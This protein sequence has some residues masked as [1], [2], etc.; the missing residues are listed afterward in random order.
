MAPRETAP[1]KA[2]TK[3][4]IPI[5]RGNV[6]KQRGGAR[7]QWDVAESN[8]RDLFK[9]HW[10]VV[11]TRMT[12]HASND[13]DTSLQYFKHLS[14]QYD[15][16]KDIKLTKEFWEQKLDSQYTVFDLYSRICKLNNDAYSPLDVGNNA[17][18]VKIYLD[19]LK[20]MDSSEESETTA[21]ATTLYAKLCADTNCSSCWNHVDASW[22]SKENP[23][24]KGTFDDGRNARKERLNYVIM[25]CLMTKESDILTDELLNIGAFIAKPDMLKRLGSIAHD[26]WALS[27]L[28]DFDKTSGTLGI[29]PLDE[30]ISDNF[31]T[32]REF[33]KTPKR[34]MQLQT[35]ESLG[36]QMNNETML[37]LTLDDL[38][39]LP[40]NT[41]ILDYASAIL[42]LHTFRK[43]AF[44]FECKLTSQIHDTEEVK[45]TCKRSNRR[46]A[47]R[48]AASSMKVGATPP[49]SA[50]AANANAVEP[51]GNGTQEQFF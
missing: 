10:D 27:R 45:V 5:G 18:N 47:V 11:Q 26:S 39:P 36:K 19:M 20:Q 30:S 2:A 41:Y 49:S 43:L 21:V 29:L 51:N 15:I 3:K 40:G 12:E 42:A 33:L 16:V 34:V 22:P 38:P 1:R 7:P 14:D 8:P 31:I 48:N 24:V 50:A 17:E 32:V 44:G 6:R 23:N 13:A 46:D 28:V 9:E 4:K 37:E 35:F 25:M